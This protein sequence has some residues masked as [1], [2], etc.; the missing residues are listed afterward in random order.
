MI[1]VLRRLA[2]PTLTGWSIVVKDGSP[3]TCGSIRKRGMTMVQTRWA[4]ASVLAVV[5]IA[6][7]MV[8]ITESI[9]SAASCTQGC[10]SPQVVCSG[11]PPRSCI[12]CSPVGPC[13][14]N[15]ITSYSNS[16]SSGSTQGSSQI[17][18]N[19]IPCTF[20]QQCV[21]GPISSGE[22]GTYLFFGGHVRVI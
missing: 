19:T 8:A 2:Y 13:P 14:G 15:T 1:I 16:A 10:A 5:L 12:A 22:C 18:W 21:N 6:L 20:T 4:S 9:T 17:S 7:T 3:F 11:S